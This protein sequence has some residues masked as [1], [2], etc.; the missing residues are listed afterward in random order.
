MKVGEASRLFG[1]ILTNPESLPKER[2]ERFRAFYCGLCRSLRRRYGLTGAATLSFDMTFLG[3][4]L[5]ALY[6]PGE[7]AGEERCPPHPFRRH[8]YVETPALEYAADMNVALAYHKCLDNWRDDRSVISAAEAGL[9]RRAYRTVSERYPEKCSAIEAWLDEIHRIEVAD[10]DEL[11]PP[12]NATGRML[13]ELFAWRADDLWAEALRG[14]GEGLG[15]YIYLMDAC[16]DLKEDLKRGSYNPL[17][18]RYQEPGF[19]E[20]CRDALLMMVAD[21]TR[22]FELLPIVEDADILRNILYSGI[23]S[24]Y[25]MLRK[26]REPKEE[27]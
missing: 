27:E 15:R 2:Q 8:A 23:W 21:A 12:V 14:V 19:E 5:N 17:K 10:S 9:L 4:L 11:D 16:D 18:R 13:G 22:E 24:K 6:E 7:R 1:Y 3:L 26:K 20:M 25:A